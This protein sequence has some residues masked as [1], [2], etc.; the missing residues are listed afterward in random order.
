MTT[1]SQLVDEIVRETRRPDLLADIAEYLNQTIREMHFTPDK[2]NAIL[3]RE[4]LRELQLV[5]NS[6]S[7]FTWSIPNPA[8]FQMMQAVRYDS[9]HSH[10]G[11]PVYAPERVPGRGLNN[12]T[13]F[14]YRAG[15]V[16]VFAGYGGLNATISLAFYE[17]P[18]ELK[19]RDSIDR[20]ATY[21]VETGWAYHSEWSES[22]GR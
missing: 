10:D 18:R 3:Y 5:A 22:G 11:K 16:Y 21:D 20:L 9:V 6:E 1:F 8:T 2:G 4:N 19:Y 15:G 13:I 7:S 12:Q 14:Y 17:Y